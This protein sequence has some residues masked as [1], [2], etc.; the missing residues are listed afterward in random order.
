[1]ALVWFHKG[2]QFHHVGEQMKAVSCP[3]LIGLDLVVIASSL[4]IEFSIMF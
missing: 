2:P 1:M 4:S 3:L